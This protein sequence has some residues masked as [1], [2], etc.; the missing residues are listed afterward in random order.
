MLSLILAA[1][2]ASRCA[3]PEYCPSDEAL[4]AALQ[5]NTDATLSALMEE[6]NEAN[7]D[8]YTSMVAA[9]IRRLSDVYCGEL[10]PDPPGS[11]TC[12]LTVHYPARRSYQVVLLSRSADGWTIDD[13]LS[14]TRWTRRRP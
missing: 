4:K 6:A 9:P 11:I 1:A 5:A 7:P 13:Q 3:L 10:L 8:Q 2:A 14:V 12:R